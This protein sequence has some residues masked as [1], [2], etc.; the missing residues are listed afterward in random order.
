MRGVISVVIILIMLALAVIAS[1]TLGDPS[2]P[3]S[4]VQPIQVPNIFGMSGDQAD[5]I[6]VSAR[7][8]A[9]AIRELEKQRTMAAIQTTADASAYLTQQAG[10]EERA[11]TM[12]AESTKV[13]YVQYIQEKTAQYESDRSTLEAGIISTQSALV[14]QQQSSYVTA[15]QS[16]IDKQEKRESL[17]LKQKE[18]WASAWAFA[19]YAFMVLLFGVFPTVAFGTVLVLLVKFAWERIKYQKIQPAPNGDKQLVLY[20]GRIIDPDLLTMPIT[21]LNK[22]EE[23]PVDKQIEIK[24]A[25]QRVD[26]TRSLPRIFNQQL[27]APAPGFSVLNPGAMPPSHLLPDPDVAGVIDSEWIE[28]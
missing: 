15:T 27:P 18:I 24:M 10:L 21:D 9:D 12:I 14:F 11:F 8:T 20:H 19:G 28:S 3:A 1:N 6:A 23:I 22:P 2:Q 7:S 16:A 13:A 25:D 26:A 4:S 17:D 5:A